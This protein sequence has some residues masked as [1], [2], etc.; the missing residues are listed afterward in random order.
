M[1]RMPHSVALEIFSN[2]EP[3]LKSKW[4]RTSGNGFAK[5]VSKQP[6]V[7]VVDVVLVTDVVVEDV[8]VLVD[9][10]DDVDVELLVLVLVDDVDDVDVELLVLVDDVDDVDVELLVLVDV[11]VVTVLSQLPQTA[12][13]ESLIA[14]PSSSTNW[15]NTAT[16]AP[17]E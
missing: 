6:C 8:L 1:Q 13:H 16:S 10:V 9:D 11:L 5:R 7:V 4:R 3:I 17:N 15:Q 12:L 2:F 14:T